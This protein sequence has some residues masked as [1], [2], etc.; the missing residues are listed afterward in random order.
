MAYRSPR[1]PAASPQARW[2]HPRQKGQDMADISRRQLVTG[3]AGLAVVGSLAAACGGSSSNNGGGG[4]GGGGGPNAGGD[5]PRGVP[6]RAPHGTR[7]GRHINPHP[8]HTPVIPP[9][10]VPPPSLPHHNT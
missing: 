6:R 7:G 1:F 2:R 4:G 3:A 10:T 9:R 8:P 5:F